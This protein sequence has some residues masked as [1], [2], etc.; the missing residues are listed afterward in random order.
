MRIITISVLPDEV[1]AV[2]IHQENTFV[3]VSP[4]INGKDA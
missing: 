2:A 1:C 3:V 4:G